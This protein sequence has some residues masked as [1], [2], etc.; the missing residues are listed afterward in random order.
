MKT[1][2]T[3]MRNPLHKRF[4]AAIGFAMTV[5]TA[6]ADDAP[7]FTMTVFEDVAQG[8]DIIAGHYDKAIDAVSVG[9]SKNDAIRIESNLCV[10]YVKSGEVERAERACDAAIAAINAKKSF[11]TYR[12]RDESAAKARKRYLAIA[13]SNRG[14]VKAVK[15][16]YAAARKDLDTVLELDTQLA[17]VKINL[18]RLDIAESNSA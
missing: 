15:G 16:D 11:R 6:I 1:V 14:V 10:A 13:L 12:L 4:L 9:T 8:T 7:K 2:T 5:S 17:V 18:E 3:E